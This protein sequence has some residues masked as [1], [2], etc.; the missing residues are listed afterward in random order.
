MLD[1]NTPDELTPETPAASRPVEHDEDLFAENLDAFSGDA[2]SSSEREELEAMYGE[3]LQ[4]SE[5]NTI[6][7]GRIVRI[8]DRDVAVDIGFKSEGWVSI[9]EFDDPKSIKVGDEID[10]FV[11][12]FENE[13]GMLQ[14]SKKRADSERT[15][16]GLKTLEKD[17]AIIEGKVIRRIKGG[18]EVDVMGIVAFL[19]GSQVDIH[20]VRDF[21]GLIGKKMDFRIVKINDIRKNIVVSRKVHIEEDMREIREKV[22][23]ELE[24]GQ[25]R[26]G[27]VKNITNFG[28]FVDLGGVDG[29]LHITDLSYGRINH[30]SEVVQ[31][32]QK[33]T[34]K[35]L[36][37][38]RER[39]RISIGYK[40]LQAHPW[41]DVEN[42]FPAGSR[43]Q[44]KVVSLTRYGA[45]VE[46]D[47]GVEGLIHISEMSWT[48]HV[49]HPSQ[50]L[51]V[52]QEVEVMVLEVRKEERKISLGLKQTEANPWEEFSAKYKPESVHEGTV[53]DIVPFGVFVELEA[54]I[55]GLIH[56]SDLSWTRKLR[57]P[58][59]VVKKDDKIQ[60]KVLEF[61]QDERRIAL[62]V[63]QLQ[64]NP[65]EK[66]EQ[67][68]GVGSMLECA[69]EKVIDKGVIVTLPYGLEGFVPNSKIKLAD[70][71]GNKKQ[72]AEGETH[73]FRIL[74]YDRNN[75]KVI[76]ATPERVSDEQKAVAEFKARP[77]GGGGG[78]NQG[79]GGSMADAFLKAGFGDDAPAAPAAPADEEDKAE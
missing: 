8:T 43:V 57:H 46:L 67:E 63:K 24:V 41:N 44:G 28:V 73:L 31:L 62:G 16:I 25:V 37:F 79:G 34:V 33:I 50:L 13:S 3:T 78:G 4:N 53:R 55:E 10:V 7:S 17:A 70:D 61:N 11:E 29:L 26:E 18:L 74:E 47:Q 56:I 40:Q 22:L 75:K 42:R 14:L 21:D 49:K 30:P 59:E 45:F 76:L 15:W 36:N 68:F 52:G 19:P 60:V 69:V 58:G 12:K 9:D 35:I 2:Y 65:W 64:E 32:D 27:V 1:E 77:S 38:D 20:P 66:F 23:T 5:E 48:Q 6:A 71:E 72:P 39:N 51:S 54:G